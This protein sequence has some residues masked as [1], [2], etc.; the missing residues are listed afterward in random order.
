MAYSYSAIKDFYNCPRKYY[1][2]RILK[3]WP[4]E[5]KSEQIIYGEDVHKALEEHITINKPLGPHSRYQDTMDAL[6][7][8]PGEKLPEVRMALNDELKPVDFFAAD[9]F[10][11]GVADL[12][13]IDRDKKRATIFDYKT[14]KATYPDP[15]QLELMALMVFRL[16]PEIE[17]VK[18]ALLFVVHNKVI[19]AAYERKDEKAKWNKW[20]VKIANI[21]NAQDS[22]VWNENPTGLCGWCVVRDCPHFRERK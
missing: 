22:G 11:R 8:I 18:A 2:T 9:V 15:E 10:I 21:E 6:I 16:F 19:P 12:V 17:E 4:K 7:A 13:I 3:K 20:E 5:E 14:G 1:E